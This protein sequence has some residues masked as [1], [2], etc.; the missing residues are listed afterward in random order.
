M[1]VYHGKD[2]SARKI[3]EGYQGFRII[4]TAILFPSNIPVCHTDTVYG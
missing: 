4:T 3:L 2:K 1:I